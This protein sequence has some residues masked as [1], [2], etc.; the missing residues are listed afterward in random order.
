MSEQALVEIRD[1][2]FSYDRR[3]VLNGINMS[4]GKGKVIAVMG[5]SG[6][7]KTTLFRL[8][9]GALRP[10]RGEVRIDG[11]VIH[12]LDDKGLY[13]MRR[14][15][16]VLFQFG[17]LFTDMS[18]FDNVAFQMREHTDLPE[19]II[20]DLVMMKL[21]A[22]GLRGTHQLMPAELSGGMARRVALARTIALDPMLILY[23]EPFAGLDPISLSVVGQLIRKLN[24]ALG[25]TS[26]VVTHDVQESLKIVD[27]VYFISDGVIR[28][29]GTPDEIRASSDPFVHQFVHGEM[30][31][32]LPFHYPT[33]AT[34][35]QDM[36]VNN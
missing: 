6:C 5:G 27:Y 11:K 17:A 25:T 2:N 10:T 32:P 14:K 29:E 18:V 4:F 23:D 36:G 22:V 30:D 26:V 33:A 19:E 21:H 13:E 9:G 15:M 16:G 34:Y 3:P 20:H 28:A 31:G 24:D 8:I 1:V 35:E 7:G 12:E